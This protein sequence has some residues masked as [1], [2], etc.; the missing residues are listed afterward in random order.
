VLLVFA[1]GA[2][3]GF[4]P[5]VYPTIPVI[6][7]YISGQ[8]TLSR[9]RGFF[10]ALTFVLGLAATYAIL[11]AT[12]G[13][14]GSVLGASQRA[15]TY[16]VAA[17]CLGVGLHMANLLP[18]S[19]PTWAPAQ[20]KWSQLS[21]FV[22]A[23]ALGVLFGLVASPCAVPALTLIL[24]VIASKGQVAWGTV[25]MAFYAL[26][27][28]LPLVIIGTVTGALTSLERFTRY[29]AAIQRVGGWLLI[30]VGAYLIWR[31]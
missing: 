27:H 12:V 6:V 20:S 13:F 3:T 2:A 28:G 26:G 24:A 5:C 7:G 11:G 31:A 23:F 8:K 18:V 30:F 14:V 9:L 17:V 21:G 29:S 10:L 4:N 15:W 1:A 19:F 16:M 25:L 22:G